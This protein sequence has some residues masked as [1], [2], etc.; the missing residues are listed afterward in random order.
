MIQ[1]GLNALVFAAKK[2]QQKPSAVWNPPTFLLRFASLTIFWGNVGG[3]NELKMAHSSCE[4]LYINFN[5]NVD[6]RTPP[7][8]LEMSG[9]LPFSIEFTSFFINLVRSVCSKEVLW[10]A[11]PGIFL[12]FMAYSNVFVAPL[13]K[14]PSNFLVLLK[15]HFVT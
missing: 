4:H 2:A 5:F 15:W 14:H 8:H 3:K 7:V 12:I 10:T 13:E 9:Q 11:S 1:G 6:R